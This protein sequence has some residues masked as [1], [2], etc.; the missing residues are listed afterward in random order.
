MA[1]PPDPDLA[2]RIAQWLA[3]WKGKQATIEVGTYCPDREPAG[4]CPLSIT[5]T[6]GESGKPHGADDPHAAI[7][8]DLP[9]ML[10]SRLLFDPRRIARAEFSDDGECLRVYFEDTMFIGILVLPRLT[11]ASAVRR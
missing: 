7:L 4:T 1:T 8:L 6:L 11:S 2:D 9:D 5:T 10:L 3:G